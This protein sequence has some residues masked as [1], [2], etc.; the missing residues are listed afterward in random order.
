MNSS[1]QAGSPFRNALFSTLER[2]DAAELNLFTTMLVKYDDHIETISQELFERLDTQDQSTFVQWFLLRWGHISILS[3]EDIA[4][5]KANVEKFTNEPKTNFE[6][7]GKALKK[8]NCKSQGY[9][10]DI[11]QYNWHCGVHDIFY[12]QYEHGSVR[13][14]AADVIID[15]GAFIGDTAV[16]FNYKTGGDCTLHSFELLDENIELYKFNTAQNGFGEERYTINKLALSDVSGQTLTISQNQHQG[17]SSISDKSTDGDEI[18]T[19]SIDDYVEREALSKVDFIKMD[20]EGA[21]RATLKGARNT[22]SEHK[23]KL[24]VCLYHRWDDPVVIPTLINEM[25]SSYRYYFKWVH[26]E[27]GWEAVLL[28][29]ARDVEP[30]ND[31]Q[32]PVSIIDT[33]LTTEK[34]QTAINTLSK[35]FEKIVVE[36]TKLKYRFVDGGFLKRTFIYDLYLKLKGHAD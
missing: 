13:V 14:A 6:F 9:D 8:V 5:Y 7:Q 31:A 3:D 10:F 19:I 34:A 16:L 30:V 4:T 25:Y 27:R 22:I 24:A 18:S 26:L 12:N 11:V 20:I 17:A 23:P 15:A 1:A 33:T 35:E 21:E 32:Q 28:A 2:I 29:D 36:N